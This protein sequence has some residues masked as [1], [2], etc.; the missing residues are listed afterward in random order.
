MGA[1]RSR[2]KGASAVSYALLLGLVGVGALVVT[3]ALGRDVEAVF[4]AISGA[5]HDATGLGQV[6]DATDGSDGETEDGSANSAPDFTLDGDR[7][8]AAGLA[9]ERQVPGFITSFDPGGGD[10]GQTLAEVLITCRPATDCGIL[11]SLTLGTDGTLTFRPSGIEGEATYDVRVRDSGG[12]ANGGVDLSAVESFTITAQT[13]PMQVLSYYQTSEDEDIA[14][15]EDGNW[16]FSSRDASTGI[17]ILDARDVSNVTSVSTF[18]PRTSSSSNCPLCSQFPTDDSFGTSTGLAVSGDYLYVGYDGGNTPNEDGVIVWD[19]SQ[20]PTIGLV[21]YMQREDI[22]YQDD[23]EGIADLH[24]DGSLGIIGSE[25]N[26]VVRMD[27]SDPA[28][29]VYIDSTQAP[30]GSRTAERVLAVGSRGYMAFAENDSLRAVDL[31]PSPPTLGRQSQVSN[32]WENIGGMAVEDGY[33]YAAVQGGLSGTARGGLV[34]IE[35]QPNGDLPNSLSP[36]NNYTFLQNR[37]DLPDSLDRPHGLGVSGDILLM[38]GEGTTLGAF[39]VSDP[40][41]PQLLGTITHANAL[42][43]VREMEI[44][45]NLAYIA[46]DRPNN[47]TGAITVLQ[48]GDR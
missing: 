6:P 42:I 34:V 40:M 46:A 14:L 22:G 19:I 28:A 32:T 20:M 48:F 43:N 18:V 13:F 3:R 9:T 30:G 17:R 2:A 1:K 47:G 38:G 29:P 10:A 27:L 25:I 8:I 36:G 31:A 23:F 5:V 21:S 37:V 24:V 15:T 16:I 33:L 11:S 26:H 7:V 35:L 39:D 41:N 45:G 12:T 44:R 4:L